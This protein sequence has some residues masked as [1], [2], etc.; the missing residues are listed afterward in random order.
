MEAL[1]P[2]VGVITTGSHGTL[3][4]LARECGPL[5]SAAIVLIQEGLK[6]L[7]CVVALGSGLVHQTRLL[8]SADWLL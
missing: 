7:F 5:P 1:L 8:S 6:L 3:V 4:Q 2:L